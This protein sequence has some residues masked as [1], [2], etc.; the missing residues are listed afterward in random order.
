M[1]GSA[2]AFLTA[3]LLSLHNCQRGPALVLGAAWVFSLVLGLGQSGKLFYFVFF[4]SP[5]VLGW[6][7]ELMAWA[8]LTGKWKMSVLVSPAETSG[9]QVCNKVLHKEARYQ[10]F[11]PLSDSNSPQC[12]EKFIWV[13][14][15]ERVCCTYRMQFGGSSISWGYHYIVC[16]PQLFTLGVEHHPLRAC[17]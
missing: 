7:W 9:G 3:A 6:Y 5:K 15:W 1:C 13:E 17:G 11:S 2:L 12:W 10:A 4:P 16:I 8:S 14:V